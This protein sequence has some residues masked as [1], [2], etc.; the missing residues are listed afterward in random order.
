M[1]N[2]V[3]ICGPLEWQ[4][5]GL[6]KPVTCRLFFEMTQTAGQYDEHAADRKSASSAPLR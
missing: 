5:W 2:C 6:N 3:E 1:G 4:N